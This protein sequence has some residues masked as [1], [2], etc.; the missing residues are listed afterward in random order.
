MLWTGSD[1]LLEKDWSGLLILAHLALLSITLSQL[2]VDSPSPEMTPAVNST[3]RWT[4]WRLRTQQ[5]ITVPETQWEKV[6]RESYKNYFLFFTTIEKINLSQCQLHC[7]VDLN[8]ISFKIHV[9]NV[10]KQFRF[11]K[12][13]LKNINLYCADK[14]ERKLKFIF[15]LLFIN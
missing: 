15:H 11:K 13:N 8:E 12:N 1:R 10:S 14:E 9:Q 3:Y 2:R 5:C 7:I 6:T 4:V